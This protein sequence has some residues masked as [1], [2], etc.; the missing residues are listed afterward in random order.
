MVK[1]LFSIIILSFLISSVFAIPKD[2]NILYG[3][4]KIN[5]Q[6]FDG[7]LESYVNEK[8]QSIINV[9]GGVYGQGYDKLI[10]SGQNGDEIKFKLS[11]NCYGDVSPITKEFIEGEMIE[12]NLEFGGKYIC[13]NKK[14]SSKTTNDGS[15]TITGAEIIDEIE[16]NIKENISDD[17]TDEETIEENMSEFM[18]GNVLNNE[19]IQKE[20]SEILDESESL[21]SNVEEEIANLSVN[22]KLSGNVVKGNPTMSGILIS[23]ILIITLFIVWKESKSRKK[24]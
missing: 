24:K 7:Q 19:T 14:I 4:I 1:K 9:N 16:S 12:F 20:I 2:P 11:N 22:N 6:E 15:D 5:S 3:S 8:L 21:I 13:N 18:I 23:L 17:I 10:I